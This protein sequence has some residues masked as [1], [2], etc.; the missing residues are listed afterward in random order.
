MN[1]V[2]KVCTELYKGMRSVVLSIIFLGSGKVAAL[3][4]CLHHSAR[5]L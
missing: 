1:H 2:G 4:L 5:N 3:V